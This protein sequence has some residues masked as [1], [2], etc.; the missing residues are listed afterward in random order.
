[1]LRFN[2]AVTLA[3]MM[4][5]FVIIGVIATVGLSTVN[6]MKK[7]LNTFMSEFLMH[8]KLHPITA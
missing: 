4:I 7:L 6:L 2:K 8:L 1:M 5:V 3:E